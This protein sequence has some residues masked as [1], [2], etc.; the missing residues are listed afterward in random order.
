MSSKKRFA[1]IRD[2]A[3]LAG[4][5]TATVSRVINKPNTTSEETREKVLKAIDECG[6]TPNATAATLFEGTS[7]TIALFVLDI[8]NPFYISLIKH[9]NQ[10]LFQN[11]YNLIICE[12]EDS[13]EKERQ[14]YNHCKSIRCCGIIYTAGT[15]RKNSYLDPRY[16]I[17]LVLLDRAPFKEIPSFSLQSD[18][19]KMLQLLVNYLYHLNHRKIGF[20]GGPDTILSVRERYQSF[21]KYMEQYHLP[22]QEEYLRFGTFNESTGINA[23]DYF[24]SLSAP[25]TAIIAASDQIAQG[26]VMRANALGLGI[27]EEF[28]ICGIDAVDDHFYPKITSVRQNTELLAQTAFDYICAPPLDGRSYDQVIDVSFAIGQTCRRLPD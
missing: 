20:I 25:P 5:S 10:I 18:N 7:R 15:A 11:G 27:P 4:V 1:S 17:P 8:S 3:K 28:S 21:L 14:Y 13:P 24:Y 19:D 23:F 6:Y 16:N 22:V 9:L 12:T 2:V 26:F